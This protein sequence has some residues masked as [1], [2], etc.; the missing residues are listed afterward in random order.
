MF[1]GTEIRGAGARLDAPSALPA[2]EARRKVPFR[3]RARGLR[4]R[5]KTGVA[6][7]FYGSPSCLCVITSCSLAPAT[8]SRSSSSRGFLTIPGSS[9]LVL[10]SADGC[11]PVR[12]EHRG[13]DLDDVPDRRHNCEGGDRPA[14][15]GRVSL[16]SYG[17]VGS[18]KGFVVQEE[19]MP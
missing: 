9:T 12:Y 16:R 18:R 1:H 3:S 2:S 14:L 6:T 11:C 17:F 5:S 19:A 8:D 15:L 10:I 7:P 4:G 13:E